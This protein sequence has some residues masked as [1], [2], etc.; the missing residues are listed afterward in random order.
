M[1]LNKTLQK[2]GLANQLNTLR[3]NSNL[4][5]ITM[6]NNNLWMLLVGF[7]VLSTTTFAQSKNSDI[8]KLDS[9]FSQLDEVT[10]TSGVIDIA[11]VRE[12]HL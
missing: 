11:K 7:L 3:Y 2:T 9:L 8:E 4:N 12:T 6:K 1:K 5:L 10:V